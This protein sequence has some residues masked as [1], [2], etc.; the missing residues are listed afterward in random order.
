MSLQYLH[1]HYVYYVSDIFL[2]SWFPC[3]SIGNTR[4]PTSRRP[5]QPPLVNV[6]IW[7]CGS[8]VPT[9]ASVTTLHKR[10]PMKN[11]GEVAIFWDYGESWSYYHNVFFSISFHHRK[12]PS[13]YQHLRLHCRG[14][15]PFRGT[16]FWEHK[17]I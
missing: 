12:L 16:K 11:N 8:S 17:I 1:W 4:L 2:A 14:Q 10:R 5:P 13:P 7:S 3:N 15:H 9:L 6:V